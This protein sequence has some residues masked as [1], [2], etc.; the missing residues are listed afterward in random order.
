VQKARGAG[1]SHT[2][3]GR[4]ASPYEAS[5]LSAQHQRLMR[6]AFGVDWH[7]PGVAAGAALA[8]VQ[9]DRLTPL[10]QARA[11][12]P[13]FGAL[14]PTKVTTPADRWSLDV[15][16]FYRQGSSALN[17][18]QGRTPIYGASQLGANLQWRARPSSAHDPRVFARAYH[19]LVEGGES[20]IAAGV[21]ARPVGSI[22][23]RTYGELRVTRNPASAALDA[24]SSTAVRP[25]AYA[26][27]EL[28]PLDLPAGFG[29]EAYGAAGYVFGKADTYFVDGQAAVTNKVLS[30][31][32]PGSSSGA[33]SVGGG[34][35]GGTQKGAARLDVGPTMRLDVNVGDVPA[36]V[37]VDYRQQVAGDAVPDSGVA[38]TVSTR[39]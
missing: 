19:A 6:E 25:A 10:E 13:R 20:E 17:V 8:G 18:S 38:A 29:L 1:Q 3:Y 16:G 23:L 9:G 34:I 11:A 32:G 35:W 2:D 14:T 26:V 27:T 21:S 33:L 5:N 37:S 12:P 4:Y 31:G 15:F 39:F 36:R 7:S 28:P 24:T 22:P 30:L